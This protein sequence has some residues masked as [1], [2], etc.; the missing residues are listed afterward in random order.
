[1]LLTDFQNGKLEKGVRGAGI[2][3]KKVA[4]QLLGLRISAFFL[5]GLGI[6]HEQRGV[7]GPG[8]IGGFQEGDGHGTFAAQQPDA[9]FH[10][11]GGRRVQILENVCGLKQG[12]LI[13]I[14]EGLTAE[15]KGVDR[16][17]FLGKFVLGKHWQTFTQPLFGITD[18]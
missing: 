4:D 15:Q 14:A 12:C 11:D 1:M 3:D 2:F 16:L 8:L 6:E 9:C 18:L 13:L 17:G 7:V 10:P 5:E